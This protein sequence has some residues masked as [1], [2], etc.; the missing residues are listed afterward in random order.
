MNDLTGSSDNRK[1]ARSIGRFLASLKTSLNHHPNHQ[2]GE[3]S[4][5]RQPSP[6]NKPKVREGAIGRDLSTT[7]TTVAS[8]SP[9]S[10]NLLS[11]MS[12]QERSGRQGHGRRMQRIPSDQAEP[13]AI[14]KDVPEFP[15]AND[16]EKN[17][18]AWLKSGKQGRPPAADAPV[19]R[20][21]LQRLV[22]STVDSG[23]GA[24]GVRF[25]W[26]VAR[27][28][29]ILKT[30][31]AETFQICGI[32][33]S[34]WPKTKIP[35]LGAS[36][37][38]CRVQ[39]MYKVTLPGVGPGG[40]D[41][42][43]FVKVVPMSMWRTQWEAENQW[44]G[45]YATD[46]ENFV[47]EAA[48]LAFLHEY[49]PGI[50]PKLMG[51]L[52]LSASGHLQESSSRNRGPGA[53]RRRDNGVTH[54]I[55]ISELYGEDL[56]DYLDR[57]DRKDKPLS[58]EEKR[59]LQLACVLLMRKLHQLGLAH[60]DFTPE[61]ILLGQDGLRLCDFAKATPLWSPRLRHVST[62][63]PGSSSMNAFE[64]C[65][66][67]VGKGAYMPPECWKI[68]WK[69]ETQKIVRPL[70]D[71]ASLRQPEERVPFYFRV[72]S[73]DVYM[74]GVVIFWIW[75]EGGI[76][77]CSDPRQDEKFYHLMKSGMNFDL[78][79]ECR[80]WPGELKESL[81][82]ALKPEPWKRAT[83]SE[84]LATPWYAEY[85]EGGDEKG[86]LRNFLPKGLQDMGILEETNKGGARSRSPSPSRHEPGP[87]R[88]LNP[89]ST[90][91]ATRSTSP[92]RRL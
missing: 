85:L 32:P 22:K 68:Y 27:S 90:A 8:T 13:K 52:E 62:P 16:F 66:P 4:G 89:S 65:E 78:F 56:L 36:P 64:S 70:E 20:D 24:A 5:V 49:A 57:R 42:R 25:S 40:K 10:T 84:L 53:T 80:G 7:P 72:S 9:S 41:I 91:A 83:V 54:V 30:Q 63:A 60:L 44:N 6:V 33:F 69:L 48:A 82:R 11:S 39:E 45:E 58:N 47:M 34:A 3:G 51:I 43:L 77:R 26:R 12:P 19:G 23:A 74:L 87:S 29:V 55:I 50:A 79:R 61:N 18:N 35:T 37:A 31:P 75:S 67:T 2:D 71:L 73:A 59:A 92:S 17:F 15:Y 28:F 1:D 76:W 81:S 86:Y 46:G 38:S 88:S 14:D 21:D